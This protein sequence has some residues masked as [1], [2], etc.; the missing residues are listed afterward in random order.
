MNWICDECGQEV[1][2]SENPSKNFPLWS[3][4]HKCKFR[5]VENE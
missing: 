1:I 3:D 5:E 4:G 2:A